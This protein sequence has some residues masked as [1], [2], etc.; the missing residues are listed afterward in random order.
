MVEE[1]AELCSLGSRDRTHWN[2]SYCAW[3]SL[4]LTLECISLLRRSSTGRGFLERCL[5][6]PSLPILKKH[7]DNA[8]TTVLWVLVSP[9][10]V[11]QLD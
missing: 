8:L 4:V 2:G 10:V 5:D 3:G 7:L 11:E 6:T 9:E 1:G